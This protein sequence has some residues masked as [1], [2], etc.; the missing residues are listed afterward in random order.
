MDLHSKLKDTPRQFPKNTLNMI[1]LFHPSTW[2]SEIYIKQAILGDKSF[3][4][5]KP[6]QPHE[7]SL[8]SL[9]DWKNISALALSVIRNHGSFSVSN[10]WRN[11]NCTVDLPVDVV[12]N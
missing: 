9:Q 7:D 6:I 1:F 12:K 11:P 10:I 5:H 8:F 4:N 2:N 3:F